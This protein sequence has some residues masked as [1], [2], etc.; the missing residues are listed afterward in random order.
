MHVCAQ[1]RDERG[2]A[3]VCEPGIRKCVNG[4]VNRLL[5]EAL[6]GP[7]GVGAGADVDASEGADACTCARRCGYGRGGCDPGV[8]RCVIDASIKFAPR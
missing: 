7:I 2:S 8:R 1:A 5:P 4:S 6:T 3:R